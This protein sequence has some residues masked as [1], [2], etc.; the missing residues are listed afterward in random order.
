MATKKFI[1][2]QVLYKL[3]GGVPDSAFPVD[4]RDIWAS[5]NNKIN[6]LFKIKHID[7]TLPSGETLPENSMIATYEGVEVVS[8]DNGKSY[9]L[10]PIQPISLPMN[11]GIFFVYD[12]RYPD[13]F[14]VPLQRS[15]LALLRADELLNNLMGQAG[16]EPKNDRIIITQDI[17]MYGT[18]ELTMEL[19]VMDVSSYS[20][21]ETLPIPADYVDRIIQ[22]LT[23][24]F[25]AVLPKTGLVNNF[26]NE[27]QVPQKQ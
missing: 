6:S 14:L 26:T 1:S 3:A 2:D 8:M 12:P 17:T 23:A 22:E 13:N 9:A 21:T 4:E 27:S 25:G 5:L 20:V 11:A 24:E 18:E 7:T 16:Y 10:L 15:Q 19:C